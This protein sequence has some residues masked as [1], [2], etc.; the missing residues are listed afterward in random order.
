MTGTSMYY[1]WIAMR[2][3]CFNSK[4]KDFVNYGGRGITVCNRWIDSFINFYNDMGDRPEK[5]SL[6]RIDNDGDY[7]PSNC[8]W[9]TVSQQNSNQ[10]NRKDNTSRI[11]GVSWNQPHGQW[12]IRHKGNSLG[13]TKDFFEACCVKKS[14]EIGGTNG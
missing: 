4:N 9:A 6:D 11:K 7:S 12:H 1:S 3:R 10:R 2:Q 13:Y 14:L 5:L 8:R